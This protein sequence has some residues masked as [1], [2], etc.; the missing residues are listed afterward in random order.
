MNKEALIYIKSK[1]AENKDDCIEVVTKGKF[2]KKLDSYYAVYEETELSGMEGTTTTLKIKPDKVSLI[3][4]GTTNARIDFQYDKNSVSLYNT[5]Y[6]V[7]QLMVDT[8]KIKVDV[9]ENGGGISVDYNMNIA[10]QK[11]LKTLLNIDI[12]VK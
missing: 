12:K 11:P 10:G 9:D 1:Q 2:Y 8:K 7:L 3:R 4:M 6:G 5:A